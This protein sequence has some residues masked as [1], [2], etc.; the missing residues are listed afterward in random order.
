MA[1][2]LN[3]SSVPSSFT[4][5]PVKIHDEA[6]Q[7]AAST[8]AA[9]KTFQHF[10]KVTSAHSIGPFGDL[11]ALSY[12]EGDIERKTLSH[13]YACREHDAVISL[14]ETG[15]NQH[16]PY[17]GAMSSIFAYIGPR[18][19]ALDS[20]DAPYVWST[21]KQFLSEY[22]T[23]APH[24]LMFDTWEE[25]LRFRVVNVAFRLLDAL[26]QW[27]LGI[28]LIPDERESCS[29]FYDSAA[30]VVGLTNDYFS[31]HKEQ[32]APDNRG[33]STVPIVKKQYSMSDRDALL[34]VKGLAVDAEET[35]VKLAGPLKESSPNVKKYIE[36]VEHLLGG[37]C[38]W[39]ASAP[40]YTEL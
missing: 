27:T 18:I 10:A 33:C 4:R 30:R 6:P 24:K 38:F 3:T 13:D 40:R 39:A 8:A 21:L 23:E 36:G 12:P 29:A 20:T 9:A 15:T 22:D 26:V 1:T 28:Q 34:F 5:F 16:A 19:H 25:C 37:S 14:L 35:V 2:P 32:R 7:I 11:C 31:Y 17:A